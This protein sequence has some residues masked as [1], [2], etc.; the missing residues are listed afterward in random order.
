MTRRNLNKT[1]NPTNSIW[2]ENISENI[3][4]CEL[5]AR[6]RE[7]KEKMERAM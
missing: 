5:V 1:S 6:Y 4:T 3:T 7:K 2:D